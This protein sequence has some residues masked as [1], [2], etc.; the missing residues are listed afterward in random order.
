M[1]E[2]EPPRG[3]GGADELEPQQLVDRGQHEDHV[4]LG[5]RRDSSGSNGSPATA[6]DSSTILD[7][8]ETAINSS[9]I[10]AISSARDPP[11]RVP[12]RAGRAHRSDPAGPGQLL[13]VE[14]VAAALGE[15][16]RAGE[17]VD[18]GTD[19]RA[20]SSGPSGASSSLDPRAP[21]ALPSSAASRRV[22]ALR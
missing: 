2:S 12:R 4:P 7:S 15:Q 20:A 13:E 14:R 21:R 17:L 22:G 10:A 6:A 1:P 16:Q 5:D 9:W 8:S 3:L 19:Q 18:L 11:V